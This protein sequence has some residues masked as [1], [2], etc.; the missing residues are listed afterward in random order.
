MIVVVDHQDSFVYNLVQFVGAAG[1]QVTVVPSVGTTAAEVRKL[2]PEGVILSPGPGR[3]SDAGCFIELIHE[4]PNTLPIFGVCLGHQA[5]A[6]AYGGHT[7]KAPEPIHGKVSWV[8][9]SGAGLFSGLPSPLAVGRYHSLVVDRATVPE[10]LE[11]VA[12]TSD[13]LVMALA[14][15]RWPRFGV[16]F[17]PESVL[18]PEG[19]EIMR[20]FLNL[21]R[22][23]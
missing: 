18:T 12:E 8:D 7:V 9:H 16:Q 21:V 23:R 4:L 19:P 3:P 15:R 20:A 13:G 10:E 2:Q 14:H 1:H 5:L 17:H 6:E 22:S 11:V